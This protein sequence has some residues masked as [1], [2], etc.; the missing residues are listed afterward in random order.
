[1]IVVIV[2]F[3]VAPDAL[4]NTIAALEKDAVAAR[5]MRGCLAFRSL[6]TQNDITRLVLVEEWEDIESF[7]MY[8]TSDAFAAAMATIKPVLIGAPS[9]RTFIAT[10]A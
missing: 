9:S 3:E 8:K 2:E 4:L 1:M 7:E 10:L 6:S 5:A